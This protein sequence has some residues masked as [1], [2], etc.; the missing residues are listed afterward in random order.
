LKNFEEAGVIDN[1]S[2]KKGKVCCKRDLTSEGGKK[3]KT[4]K[5]SKKKILAEEMEKRDKIKS[6]GKNYKY[7][8]KTNRKRNKKNKSK[9]T[10]IT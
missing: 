2:I 4:K 8:K 1:K 10:K 5:T 9:K 7:L 6:G 3:I